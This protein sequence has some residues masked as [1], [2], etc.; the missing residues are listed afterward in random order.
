M[1]GGIVRG[2]VNEITGP[3]SSGKTA[4]AWRFLASATRAGELG[5]VIDCGNHFDA[6]SA[7]AIGVELS[8]LLLA[9]PGNLRCAL[10]CTE[11]VLVGGGFAL[12]VLDVGSTSMRG[13]ESSAWLR[14]AKRAEHSASALLLLYSKPLAGPSA[15]LSLAMHRIETRWSVP[16]AKKRPCFATLFCG[17]AVEVRVRRSRVG[18]V[19][20]SA[21][22]Y[23]TSEEMPLVADEVPGVGGGGEEEA[24]REGSE[25]AQG[26]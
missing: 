4:L 3:P 23:F 11:E 15:F 26:G 10:R 25:A 12:V 20:E 8:R 22:V 5:A 14:L 13:I 2:R 9:F 16:V 18:P 6:S 17:F 21:V 24:G 19:G 1:R 7:E